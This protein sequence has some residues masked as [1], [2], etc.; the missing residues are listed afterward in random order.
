MADQNGDDTLELHLDDDFYRISVQGFDFLR[1]DDGVLQELLFRFQ[2]HSGNTMTVFPVGV[3]ASDFDSQ[4]LDDYWQIGVA[5][6]YSVLSTFAE[7]AR[8]MHGLPKISFI[9]PSS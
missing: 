8:K 1:N 9:S 2:L 4:S 5:T 6:L 7:K 3:K